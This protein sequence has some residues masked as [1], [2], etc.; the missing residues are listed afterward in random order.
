MHAQ[1]LTLA[2]LSGGAMLHYYDNISD[3][4]EDNG[5]NYKNTLKR[6]ICLSS[7]EEKITWWI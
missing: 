6:N 4:S 3:D 1:A 5:V 7:D 2:E